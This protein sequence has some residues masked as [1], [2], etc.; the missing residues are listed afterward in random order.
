MAKTAEQMGQIDVPMELNVSSKM[1]N[2]IKQSLTY[3]FFILPQ[4]LDNRIDSLDTK[5]ATQEQ[6]IISRAHDRVTKALPY[7]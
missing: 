7:A 5:M 3:S 1:C 4:R 2:T 6:S